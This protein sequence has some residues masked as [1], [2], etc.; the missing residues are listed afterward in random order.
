L[1]H[2]VNRWSWML[3]QHLD[4]ICAFFLSFLYA[5]WSTGQGKDM[6]FSE[7]DYYSVVSVYVWLLGWWMI[8]RQRCRRNYLHNFASSVHCFLQPLP[9]STNVK[10]CPLRSFV[11]MHPLLFWFINLNCCN[12]EGSYLIQKVEP[13]YFDSWGCYFLL[14]TWLVFLSLTK[15]FFSYHVVNHIVRRW[16]NFLLSCIMFLSRTRRLHNLY[17]FLILFIFH[18]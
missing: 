5:W 11:S 8:H 4:W 9:G 16:S 13:V 17:R 7:G 15:H 1:L 6:V 12:M 18:V 3:V 10:D 2:H 14:P